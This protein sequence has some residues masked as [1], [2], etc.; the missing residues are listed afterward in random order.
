VRCATHA[1]KPPHKTSEMEQLSRLKGRQKPFSRVAISRPAKGQPV[2]LVVQVPVNV[3]LAT[4]V[5]IQING[6]DSGLMEPFRRC[7]PVGCF[8]AIALK[9]DIVNAFRAAKTQVRIVYAN[10]ARQQVAVPLSLRGLSQ[11]FNALTKE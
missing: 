6:K 5:K 4:S 10:G 3:W 9:G 8:A 2:R 7:M 1:D 11:A